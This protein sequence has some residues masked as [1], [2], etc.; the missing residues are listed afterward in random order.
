MPLKNDGSDSGM[1]DKLK[2]INPTSCF[3][4]SSK[5]SFPIDAPSSTQTTGNVA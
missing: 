1:N 3:L 2:Q 4:S 5:S